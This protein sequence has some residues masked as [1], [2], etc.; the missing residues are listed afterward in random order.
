MAGSVSTRV[1]DFSPRSTPSKDR[2]RWNDVIFTLIDI[3]GANGTPGHGVQ[4][5]I[6]VTHDELL[7][8][9]RHTITETRPIGDGGATLEFRISLN[10]KLVTLYLCT[11]SRT[12]TP[13][14]SLAVSACIFA[15]SMTNHPITRT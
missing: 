13:T 14:L 10:G 1:L 15:L 7:S 3:D 8:A 6:T 9:Y 12:R 2:R 4:G 11:L 5:T